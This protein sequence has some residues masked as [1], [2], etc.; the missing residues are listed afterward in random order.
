MTA[1][2]PEEEEYRNILYKLAPISY[3]IS[4]DK[5]VE[6]GIV[7]PYT[8]NCIPIELTDSERSDYKSINNK[9]VRC[10]Y[11]LGEYDA[12][13]Q[14]RSILGDIHSHPDDKRVAAQFYQAI[15]E[16]KAIVDFAE[17]KITAFQKLV[18]D[19]INN[20]ILVFSV[21][22]AFTDQ[23]CDS[24]APLAVSYHSKK[25]K[26]QREF[27]LESFRNN[28]VNILCSTKA[29]NQGLDIPNAN[30]GIICGLTSKSLS[31]IQRIGRLIRYEEDKIGS[32]YILYVHYT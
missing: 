21:A 20:K 17:N 15:R 19:N 31:M 2:L 13:N 24:V 25:T 22:N 14:A 5:C 28:D 4:L 10:K 11:A 1:T 30:M 27:A 18:S 16:R 9:F 7:S 3:S 23:L 6:L 8:I 12:F 26:K 32:V 29:L